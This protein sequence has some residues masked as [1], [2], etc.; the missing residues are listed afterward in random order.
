VRPYRPVS[1]PRGP[2]IVAA[3]LFVLPGTGAADDTTARADVVL[4]VDNSFSMQQPGMDPERSSL[5]MAML[6]SDIV[7]GDLAVVRMLDLHDDVALLPSRPTGASRPCDEDPSRQCGVVEPTV[8]WG[9]LVH[10]AGHGLL[11]RPAR[12][13]TAFKRD[14]APHL[15]QTVDNTFAH[16]AFRGAEGLFA[17]H[18]TPDPGVPRHVIWLTDGRAQ[19][20]HVLTAAIRD[21]RAH[22]VEVTALVFRRGDATIPRESGL[23][24]LNVEGPASLMDAFSKTFREIVQAP[25]HV[26]RELRRLPTFEME[27]FVDEAWVV[28]YGDETLDQVRLEDPAATLVAADYAAGDWPSAGAY[29]VAF[30]REPRPG[31]WRVEAEGGG[32]P[33]YAVVQRARFAPRPQP[34]P[35]P[36]AGARLRLV[37]E[38]VDGDNFPITDPVLLERVRVEAEVEGLS[39][40]LGDRGAHGDLV[41]GDGQFSGWVS[42]SNEGEQT[43]T[44]WTVIEVPGGSGTPLVD[45]ET[46][47]RIDVAK[48][49]RYD[50]APLEVDLGTIRTGD[51]AC[52]P[53]SV[54]TDYARPVLFEARMPQ[55]LPDHHRLEL[56]VSDKGLVP[57]GGALPLNGGDP[58]EV[59]LSTS[60]EAGPSRGAGHE[61]QLVVAGVEGLPNGVPLLV[62]WSVELLPFW[63]RYGKE[64]AAGAGTLALA[65]L[66]A[67]LLLPP[68]F[69]RG[70]S[71]VFVP[72]YDE[73]NE[74]PAQPLRYWGRVGRPFFRPA[75]TYLRLDYRLSAS[76]GNAVAALVAGRKAARVMAVHGIALFRENLAGDW[77]TV[78]AQGRRSRPGEVYRVGDRG[79][80]FRIGR[81]AGT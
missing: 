7:P 64:L 49:F 79:P 78:A 26:D 43:V 42:F 61:L 10:D 24:V 32:E 54:P 22:G 17:R 35:Q 23:A 37:T 76:P 30:V 67:G 11:V 58:F 14:L 19:Q 80:Y 66:A 20:Q 77:E 60:A 6:F 2:A 18:G 41:A 28:V 75:R 29:R 59:C 12:G 31:T 16:L 51:V 74:Q 72:S 21:V 52:A 70:L 40:P 44:I 63:Q 25:Y 34:P 62:S 57:G 71:L 47:V 3:M 73:L 55:P 4:I 56:R 36:M 5:L 69:D 1:G 65:L 38:V 15:E 39:V 33:A 8:P 68:R 48:E 50:G 81:S 13:D 53:A 9:P 45:Q 46:E 27:P